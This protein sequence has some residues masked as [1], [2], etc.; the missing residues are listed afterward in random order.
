MKHALPI[1]CFLVLLSAC[2]R[3][4]TTGKRIGINVEV[5]N[6]STQITSSVW[7]DAGRGEIDFGTVGVGPRNSAE[8][9]DFPAALNAPINVRW[10]F[11]EAGKVQIATN[12]L[13]RG[14]S[15]GESVRL[16]LDTTVAKASN[17]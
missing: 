17:Y 10:Q 14:M 9:G 15:P 4:P 7:V 2:G 6:F 8:Y 11:D 12:V 1:S 3:A 13:G 5:V 16:T